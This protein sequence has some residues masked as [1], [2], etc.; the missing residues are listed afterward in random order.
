MSA[1]PIAFNLYAC[2]GSP[3]GGS[4]CV[5]AECLD[6]SQFSSEA[7]NEEDGRPG[8]DGCFFLLRYL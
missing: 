1:S 5:L 7:S 3:G 4:L 2:G 8:G 6:G